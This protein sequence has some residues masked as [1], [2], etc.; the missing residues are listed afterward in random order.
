M[1]AIDLYSGIGGWS[2]GL[3]L[4]G[5]DVVESFERWQPAVDTLN[6]NFGTSYKSV[7][8]RSLNFKSLPEDI[9]IVV[10]SPPCTQ[11]SYSNRGGS[12]NIDE[13]IIDLYKFFECVSLLKPK[14]W[15]MENVPRV[16]KVLMKET[17]EGGQ[18]S[19]FS[20][21]INSGF[22]EIMD[23]SEFGTPQK[24][25]RCIAS[26]ANLF[27][28]NSYKVKCMPKSLGQVIDNLSK[29]RIFDLNYKKELPRKEIYD[30]EIGEDLDILEE[31]MNKE[32]KTNHPVYN[33][34]SFP[35]NLNLPAR[36]IT[37]TCTRVSRES[38]IVKSKKGFRRLSI[39]ERATIQG[40]PINYN[41]FG[42]SYAQKLKMI[43]N[44]IPPNF[45]YAIGSA[46]LEKNLS[47]FEKLE[48]LTF[49][50]S[51]KSSPPET[52]PDISGNLVLKRNRSFRFSPS[53]LRFKSGVRFEFSNK[54]GEFKYKFFYG[55]SKNIES[56]SLDKKIIFLLKK[57]FKEDNL[58]KFFEK[59]FYSS[60]H[61]ITKDLQRIWSSSKK[62]KGPFKIID[63]T[64]T[65]AMKVCKEVD[66]LKK[67]KVEQ[68]LS[69]ILDNSNFNNQK[70]KENSSKILSGFIVTS[71]INELSG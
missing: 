67:G 18:L 54:S 36:T 38:L 26:N 68:F 17:K 41:F 57:N 32:M 7:D 65:L 39:R 60:C 64:E 59:N 10:G 43:G 1:K 20:K 49:E 28:L 2:L 16:K 40:F 14:Y 13:G 50:T 19:K 51:N 70:I 23:M 62:S 45:S 56:I 35:E 53:Y 55:D 69:E 63:N 4:C 8:I 66:K 37:A 44:A 22:V 5:I 61:F 3:H 52:N 33:D 15:A 11:F 29:R 42:N 31:R 46:F 24:R 25:K 58:K 34:M 30:L 27:L 9:D 12:G 21:I 48:N 6:K 71:F 47:S